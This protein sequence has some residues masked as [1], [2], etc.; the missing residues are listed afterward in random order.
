MRVLAHAAYAALEDRE[1]AF[2]GVRVDGPV[3]AVHIIADAVERSAMLGEL[4]AD[5]LI[6]LGRVRQQAS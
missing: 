2:H 1:G 5:L 4:A 6:D 3:V